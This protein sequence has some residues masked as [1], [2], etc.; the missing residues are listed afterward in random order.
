MLGLLVL[1]A[2]GDLLLSVL[3]LDVAY[4]DDCERKA[5]GR[6]G[7]VPLA[8]IVPDMHLFDQV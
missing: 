4:F 8:D 1:V 2:I 7:R 3:P 5:E 6:S